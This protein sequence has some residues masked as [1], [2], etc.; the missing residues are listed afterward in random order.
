ML[1]AHEND[2]QGRWMRAERLLCE[3]RTIAPSY[4]E[5]LIRKALLAAG[6]R[7]F[8]LARTRLQQAMD[9]QPR[10]RTSLFFGYIDRLEREASGK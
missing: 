4:D 9:L 3:A 10:T 7:D 5:L 2:R 6:R 1:T 8:D